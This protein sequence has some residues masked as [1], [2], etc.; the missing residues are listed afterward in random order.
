MSYL[1]SFLNYEVHLQNV[2]SSSFTLDR[3]KQLLNLMGNPQNQL[4]IIH[5]AGSKGKGSTCALVAH[6]LK[7]AGYRVGLY[8][9]PHLYHYRERIRILGQ[10][11]PSHSEIFPDAIEETDIEET[12]GGMIAA[13]SAIESN[14][15]WGALTFFEVYTAI[16]FEYFRRQKVDIVV[17]EAG[18]GGRLDATNA[19]QSSVAVITPIS[20]E[21]TSILGD[22]LQKIATEKAAIIK[23][24]NQHVVI[25]PQDN[26]VKNI[27]EKRCEEFGIE[28]IWVD[29]Q[30]KYQSL[31]QSLRGQVVRIEG[32]MESYDS[33]HSPLIGRHQLVNM[34]V[35]VG[36]IECL[37]EEGFVIPK[38]A[39]YQGFANVFWPGRFEVISAT[40]SVARSRHPPRFVAD[41]GQN[42]PLIILDGAHNDA[43]AKVL[44]ETIKAVLPGRKV[45]LIFG[46]SNDKNKNAMAKELESIVEKV[47]ATKSHHPR[48]G[49]ISEKELQ[50]MFPG[51]ESFRTENVEQAL[52]LINKETSSSDVILVTGSLFVVS[53]MRLEIL[54][55]KSE[56]L[57]TKI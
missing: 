36:V 37:E 40:R 48:S 10:N 4:K 18:L 6:V 29:R 35:A 56:C 51:K 14:P 57:H 32:Q 3:M 41:G 20:L 34:A 17:L 8:T 12:L 47:I 11:A 9:S 19:A 31:K 49:N 30:M 46:I 15:E 44:V 52:A 1:N 33:I 21:H 42:N 2:T 55:G 24:F 43:S 28:P 53:D 50:E 22:T 39:V 16:A 13:I 23:D 7:E 5:V 45:I 38:E 26:S 27:F 25:A 54:K